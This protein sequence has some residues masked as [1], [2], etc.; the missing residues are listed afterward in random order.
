[1][2]AKNIILAGVVGLDLS[3]ASNAVFVAETTK[4]IDNIDMFIE[5]C[6]DKKEGITYTTK[7]ERFDILASRFKKLEEAERLKDKRANADSWTDGIVWKV[8][9]CRTMLINAKAYEDYMCTGR[10]IGFRH[11]VNPE[12]KE[13][14]FTIKEL[15]AM[16]SIGSTEDIIGYSEDGTL[17]AKLMSVYMSAFKKKAAYTALG[18]N[19]RKVMSLVSMSS[20]KMRG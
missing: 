3:E 16:F 19:A 5:Y 4:G 8:A 12:T 7:T 11:L 18:T 14:I 2:Q 10:D 6:R 17:K 1:M 20:E 13:K 15:T 9:Q